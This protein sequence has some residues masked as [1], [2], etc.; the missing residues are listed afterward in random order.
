MPQT[1]AVEPESARVKLVDD[2]EKRHSF[3]AD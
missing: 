2:L 3:E 1:A